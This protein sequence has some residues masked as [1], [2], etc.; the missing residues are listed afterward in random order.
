VAKRI[1]T[2]VNGNKVPMEYYVLEENYDKAEKLL[3]L[4]EQST[5]I[6]EKYFGEYPG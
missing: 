1:Y 6:Q 2:T 4:F 5:H 3:D